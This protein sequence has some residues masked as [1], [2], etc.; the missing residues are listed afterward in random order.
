MSLSRHRLLVCS[1]QVKGRC[2]D[3]NMGGRYPDVGSGRWR[4][5]WWTPTEILFRG[6]SVWRVSIGKEVLTQE[7]K[8]LNT[9][10][11]N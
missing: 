6:L 8:V 5:W 3:R 4:T 1:P 7:D 10:C 11:R 2:L 9:F